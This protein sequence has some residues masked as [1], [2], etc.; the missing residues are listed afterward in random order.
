M[1]RKAKIFARWVLAIHLSLIVG[2]IAVVFFASREVYDQARKQ[3]IDQAEASQQLLARQT[4]AGIKAF[5]DSIRDDLDLIHHADEEEPATQPSTRPSLA[6][7]N[8]GAFTLP[9]PTRGPQD[10]GNNP[11][12][13]T[14][15]V[16]GQLLWL[17]L[18]TRAA[19][20]FSVDAD[21]LEPRETTQ[22][23]ARNPVVHPIGPPGSAKAART[24]LQK[25]RAWLA[26][27]RD[28]KVSTF[29]EFGGELGDGNVVCVPAPERGNDKARRLLVAYV[30]IEK[31]R[32]KFL[33]KLNPKDNSTSATLADENMLTMV[34]SDPSLV[35]INALKAEDPDVRALANAALSSNDAVTLPIDR[36]YR[37][38]SVTRNPRMMTMIPVNVM[39]RQ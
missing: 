4:A 1:E 19:L 22:A 30:K 24:V 15:N 12:D 14:G 3:A 38:G 20:L 25:M 36:S 13:R 17:Q 6:Q 16:I 32:A 10:A 9:L 27:A 39:G 28:S 2:V 18:D 8:L 23:V 31:I 26:A 29:Q 33:D 5:Y 11:R 34:S 7:I 35:G 21:R 37:F